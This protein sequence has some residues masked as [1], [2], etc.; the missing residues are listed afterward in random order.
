MERNDLPFSAAELH[1]QYTALCHS[2]D[3]RFPLSKCLG[4]GLT[5]LCEN[6]DLQENFDKRDEKKHR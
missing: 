4:G 3:R 2:Y 5:F 6:S 1:I